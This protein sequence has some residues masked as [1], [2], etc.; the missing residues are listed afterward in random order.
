MGA[1]DGQEGAMKTIAFF[2]NKG[3]VGKTSLLYHLAHMFA[4][5]GRRVVVA[6]FDPQANL[7]SM[8]L[9]DEAIGRLWFEGR[10]ATVHSAMQPLMEGTGDLR[11]VTPQLVAERLALLPGDLSLS[12][13]EDELS[14]QWPRC[15]E[16]QARAFRVTAAFGR[17]LRDAGATQNA[18]LGLID[19]GPNLGAINRCAL[20]SAD[21]VVIPMGVDLFSIRGLENVGPKLRAWRADWQDRRERAPANL[22]FTLSN[23]DMRPL[24]YVVSRYS[25]YGSGAAKAFQR[26]LDRAP[27][28]Y[29]RDVLGQPAEPVPEEPDKNRLAQLKDYRSLMPMAQEARKP[30]FLLKPADGAIGG[31]QAA[32]TECYRDFEALSEEIERRMAHQPAGAA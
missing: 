18:D 3:G 26:W 14:A 5:R 7:T 20:I 16:R 10:G 25:S 19:V 17:M 6:D 8:F 2:N 9:R 15:L 29:L 12:E 31:H 4:L 32:V 11:S 22:G 13:V 28:V 1:C 23:G 30:M 24:G 21:Y 27:S